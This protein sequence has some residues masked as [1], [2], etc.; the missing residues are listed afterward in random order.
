MPICWIG[1]SPG[2][3]ASLHQHSLVAMDPGARV[4]GRST[5]T[6]SVQVFH[7]ARR[8]LE[9]NLL[10]NQIRLGEARRACL[11]GVPTSTTSSLKKAPWARRSKLF[12]SLAFGSYGWDNAAHWGIAERKAGV[13]L[14]EW[15]KT[16]TEAEFYLPEFKELMDDSKIQRD[17]DR[18]ASFDPLRK[19]AHSPTIAACRAHLDLP[20]LKDLPIDGVI[21]DANKE[22]LTSKCAVHCSWNLP[23]LSRG[24]E[25]DEWQLRR[26]LQKYSHD[27]RLI[28]FVLV[29][30]SAFFLCLLGMGFQ[31]PWTC[32]P[33]KARCCRS[34]WPHVWADSHEGCGSL[35]L[36]IIGE[37][38]ASLGFGRGFLDR[39]CSGNM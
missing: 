1:A 22:I 34:G 9:S 31:L 33:G 18:I 10:V 3:L 20:E 4:E 7:G 14:S 27:D 32:L 23:S 5:R 19:N 25:M 37:A 36:V 26:A 17:W 35:D 11:D 39:A 12:S 29:A 30:C 15:C 13:A 8:A 6:G 24:L 38:G 21:V 28:Q 16:K 2:M